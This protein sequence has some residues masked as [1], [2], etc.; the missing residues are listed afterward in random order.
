MSYFQ[1]DTMANDREGDAG[2]NLVAAVLQPLASQLRQ[3]N[4][5]GI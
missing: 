4:R 3:L 1:K 5:S 2:R